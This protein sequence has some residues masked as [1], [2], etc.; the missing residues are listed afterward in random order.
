V[1]QARDGPFLIAR[2]ARLAS[3][4]A[5]H[6][7]LPPDWHV[8]VDVPVGEWFEQAVLERAEPLAG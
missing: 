8:E 3:F 4:Q 5:A 1:T 2:R 6:F 7:G